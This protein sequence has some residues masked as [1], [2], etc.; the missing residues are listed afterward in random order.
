[1]LGNK[2]RMSS[3]RRLLSIILWFRRSQPLFY[4]IVC[5]AT[6]DIHSL[7]SNI[8]PVIGV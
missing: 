1:M 6:Y 2:H 3:H 7:V 5:M 8:C 4:E